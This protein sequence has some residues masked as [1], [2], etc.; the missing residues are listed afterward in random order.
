MNDGGSLIP[1]VERLSGAGVVCVGDVMLDRFVS[2]SVERIS[3][4]APIPVLRV[5]DE[6][7]MLGGAGNV[8][9][10]IASM[11]AKAE[12]VS[13]TGND[14]AGGEVRDML[15]ATSRVGNHIVEDVGRETSIK[16]R[17]LAE[18]QQMLRADRETVA[19]ISDAVADA[20]VDNAKKALARCGAM[21]L[22]D[23][24]KGVLTNAVLA[25][26][27]ALAAAAGIPA[28][29]DPKGSDY[30]CY[31]GAA[32]VTPNLNELRNASGEGA[33]DD[34][35]VVVAARK[36]IEDHGIGAV[37]ATRSADGMTL[38]TA[39]GEV[40]HLRAEGREVF[41]V[42]GAGDTVVAAMASAL[43]AGASLAEAV[44]LANTAAGIVVG[45]LGTAKVYMAELIETL[46]HQDI[47]R[48]E[49]KV[50]TDPEMQERTEIWRRQQFK[51]GFTNGCFDL[52]HPGHVS[53]L[54]QAKSAC[55]KLI[56]GLN[57]DDSV[58][59][60]KGDDRPIQSEAARATVLASLA[61]VDAVV[62][63][64]DDTP[65]RLIE[66]LKPDVLVKGADYTVETVVGADVVQKG[67]GKVVLARLADGFSTSDTIRRM[68]DGGR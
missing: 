46:H 4:E 13:V 26:L 15:A 45:K 52:L 23:Y 53:L 12:F 35:G 54:D 49:A 18:N 24:G 32:L 62:I 21:V 40:K 58:K 9:N 39:G 61:T 63:F 66:M 38:V 67:G 2:G 56:V 29:V 48:A 33:A 6:A 30:S 57:S 10:N 31:R 47:S 55:D 34:D 51:V 22:S 19:D 20:V 1:L 59:R 14:G 16:T 37:L 42:S 43:A 64:G 44:E 17:Y 25:R 27:I 5:I 36:L 60:L 11:G 28:V 50:M 68:N 3:P 8:V 41:D 65:L 7:A